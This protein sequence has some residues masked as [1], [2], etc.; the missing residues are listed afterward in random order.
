MKLLD[1]RTEIVTVETNKKPQIKCGF[2]YI[3]SNPSFPN[4][5]KVGI[6]TDVL[7]RLNT[8]QT[9]DPYRMFKI[10]HYRFV[11]DKRKTEKLIL[12]KTKMNLDKGEW[13]SDVQVKTLLL[14]L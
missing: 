5:Y 11:E 12:E 13:V 14:S 6:T 9:Y 3:I 8:Y 2:V 7:Q 4:K 1:S 10:E